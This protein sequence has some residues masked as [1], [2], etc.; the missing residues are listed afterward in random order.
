MP[1]YTTAELIAAFLA[2]DLHDGEFV[3]VGANLPVPRAGEIA[4]L[5]FLIAFLAFL[6]IFFAFAISTSVF[7]DM[8]R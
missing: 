8:E 2:R 6:M 1:D 5:A 3:V 7:K 4:F